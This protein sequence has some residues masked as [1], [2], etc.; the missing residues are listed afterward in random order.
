MAWS[1]LGCLL[2]IAVAVTHHLTGYALALLLWPHVALTLRARRPGVQ[3]PIAMAVVATVA[4]VTWALVVAGD[5]GQ[6]PRLHLRPLPGFGI[7]ERER[8]RHDARALPGRRGGRYRGRRP[9]AR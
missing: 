9:A 2:A 3:P 8:R 7:A 6:L 1:A 5:T 4:S